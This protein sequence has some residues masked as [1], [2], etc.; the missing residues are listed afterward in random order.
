ME[1]FDQEENKRAFKRMLLVIGIVVVV[2]GAIT[3]FVLLKKDSKETFNADQVNSNLA[4]NQAPKTLY[5]ADT[6]TW[7]SYNWSGKINTHYPSD[8]TLKE[9]VNTTGAVS[10]LEIVPPTENVA[11]TIYIGGDMKCSGITK[12]AKNKCLKNAIQVSF[13][14]DS[15]NTEVQSAFDLILENTILVDIEK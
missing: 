8:W 12:Y 14:T 2:A 7:K 10:G 1:N 5:S 9:K 6:S 11:D 4:E 15:Q 13:Y 3:A